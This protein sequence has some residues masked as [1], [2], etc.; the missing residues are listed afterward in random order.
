MRRAMGDQ[1][2]AHCAK[3]MTD[4]QRDCVLA[5]TDSKTAFACTQKRGQSGLGSPQ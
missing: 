3:A 1:F 5:A 2:I 4:K